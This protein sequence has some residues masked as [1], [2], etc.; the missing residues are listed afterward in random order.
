V[1]DK[2]TS[3]Y[4][5]KSSLVRSFILFWG[6]VLARSALSMMFMDNTLSIESGSSYLPLC[7]VLP[8]VL[9]CLRLLKVSADD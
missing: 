5:M 7:P 2:R 4:V 9:G 3:V 6:V 1:G 8:D